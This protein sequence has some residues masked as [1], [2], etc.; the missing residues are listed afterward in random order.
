MAA[1]FLSLVTRTYLLLH[2]WVGLLSTVQGVIHTILAVS[3]RAAF[4]WDSSGKFG[5]IVSPSLLWL[6]GCLTDL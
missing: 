6:L 1:D 4:Q 2:R 5:Y 3:Y